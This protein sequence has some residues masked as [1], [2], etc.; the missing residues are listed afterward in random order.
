MH[1]QLSKQINYPLTTHPINNYL[2]SYIN[3]VNSLFTP[4]FS[5]YMYPFLIYSLHPN[6]IRH[7]FFSKVFQVKL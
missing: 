6:K 5:T 7:I 2:I 1:V 4:N 3:L